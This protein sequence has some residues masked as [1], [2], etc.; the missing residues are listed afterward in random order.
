MLQQKKKKVA[1][2]AEENS[3]ASISRK[4]KRQRKRGADVL[5]VGTAYKKAC[6]GRKVNLEKVSIVLGYCFGLG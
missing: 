5:T 4:S 3:V 6:D 2:T 1:S